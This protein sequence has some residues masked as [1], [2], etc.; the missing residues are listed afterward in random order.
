MKIFLGMILLIVSLV[1]PAL[2]EF[3]DV[4]IPDGSR[5]RLWLTSSRLAALNTAM[6]AGSPEWTR[7]QSY[8]NSLLTEDPWQGVETGIAPLALIYL[9]TLNEQ[10]ATRAF[11][12]MDR[13]SDDISQGGDVGH[14]DYG[15][16]AL[17]YDWLYN[18]PSMTLARRNAY[19]AKMERLS[20]DIWTNYNDSG[21]GGN[22]QDT[23]AILVSGAHHLMFGCALYGDSS[24]ARDML[25]RAWW[26]W[27]HGQG[28]A[29]S[30]GQEQYTLAQPI[31]DWIK[32]AH[33]GHWHTGFMYFMGTDSAGLGNYYLSL[34]TACGYDPSTHEPNLKGFWPNVI[35]TM[36]D[37]TTPPRSMLYHTGDWQDPW[38]FAEL[39]YVYKL[40]SMASYEAGIEGEVIWDAYGRGFA[41]IIDSLHNDE[42][43]EFFYV[44]PDVQA[45][46]P[47]TANLPFIRFCDGDDFV[48][49][50]DNWGTTARWGLFSGQG[51]IPADHQTS[52]IGNFVLFREDD[53]LTK[54]RRLY[55]GVDNGPAFNNFAIENSLPNGSPLMTGSASAASIARYRSSSSDASTGLNTPY[56]YSMMQGDEQWDEDPNQWQAINR[57]TTYR[58]HFFWSGDVAVVFDRLRT[59][60]AGWSIYRLHAQTQPTLNGRTITQSSTNGKHVLLHQ[61]LEP[62]N[63]TFT[64]VN[65]KTA[66]Q[67]MFEDYEINESER[68]WHYAIQP[69]ESD[70]VNMLSVMQMGPTGT[71][72]FEGLEH[73]TS[74]GQTGAKLGDWCLLFSA[75]ETLR[76]MAT[77]T[78]GS[79][80]AG[81][82]HLVCDLSPGTYVVSL[83]GVESPE[84]IEVLTNDNTALF[85]TDMTTGPM[86][87]QLK[88]KNSLALTPIWLFLLSE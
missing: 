73:L 72:Q 71:T 6:Q 4:Y 68:L 23:D 83:N 60:D 53:Y 82:H 51:T 33:G 24:E 45:L 50:R 43:R 13:V 8:C 37:V 81:L 3:P 26:L 62:E 87:V 64:L 16:L 10:Y 18:H 1:S 42:F 65:E 55:G 25:D 78:I 77:Y 41:N 48:F 30:S 9:L 58:R 47:Y 54:D 20:R 80:Q 36:L 21:T 11:V 69:P 17:G 61:T 59:T 39:S 49:F 2:A 63:C 19:I 34:R 27:K 66:W 84:T 74:S 31:R 86:V 14:V 76:D 28:A 57:V 70:R 79:P 38:G 67:S 5:P 44:E 15:F 7:F 12:F 22:A 85:S 29:P 35:R 52:D 75:E 88:R 40:L 56:V 46:N 32:K